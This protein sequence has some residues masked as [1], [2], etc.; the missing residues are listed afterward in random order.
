MVTATAEEAGKAAAAAQEEAAS[1]ASRMVENVA[2]DV[3]DMAGAVQEAAGDVQQSAADAA[4]STRASADAIE[5]P[6][7]NSPASQ[8]P[9]T[10]AGELPAAQP[11]VALLPPP[12]GLVADGTSGS[13][14]GVDNPA[15]EIARLKEQLVG[16]LAS[17]DRG[18]AASEDQAERVDAVVTR[19]EALGGPVSLS[20][21]QPGERGGG[22]GC[23]A[24]E[25]AAVCSS[26]QRKVRIQVRLHRNIAHR[27]RRL[28]HVCCPVGAACSS[29]AAAP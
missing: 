28:R 6:A 18:A 7:G 24:G 19:L 23:R 2:S 1:A 17:L 21:E 12:E 10:P 29:A 14:A 27:L 8:Q 3:A 4:R 13:T 5:Q 22:E 20:W 26:F 11:A 9:V 15:A 25:Q 16:M